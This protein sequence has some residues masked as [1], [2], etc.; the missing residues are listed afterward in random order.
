[1]ASK[2]GERCRTSLV[3]KKRLIEIGD[4]VL[5]SGEARRRRKPRCTQAQREAGPFPARP[6]RLAPTRPF[7]G[8]WKYLL[9]ARKHIEHR[10]A[11][12]KSQPRPPPAPL[13]PFLAVHASR[14]VAV[15]FLG[16]APAGADAASHCLAV[17][18]GF[19]LSSRF[20]LAGSG[21]APGSWL[22]CHLLQEPPLTWVRRPSPVLH[23]TVVI[24]LCVFSLSRWWVLGLQP[25]AREM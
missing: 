1:M 8:A 11:H 18:L 16:L 19:T 2:Q 7:V 9:C 6:Q 22:R 21:H 20:H 14:A 24:Q 10:S 23:I 12:S 4:I 3:I 5:L 15:V 25:G 17:T 13:C